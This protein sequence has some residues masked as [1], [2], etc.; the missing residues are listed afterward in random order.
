VAETCP[1][2]VFGSGAAYNPSVDPASFT[3]GVDNPW[4]P[5][6]VGTTFVYSG[7]AD[8]QKAVD[9][10][11]PTAATRLIDG[12]ATR[13]VH[14]RLYHNGVLAERTSDYFAQDRCGNVWYFGED[15]A[16]LDSHG[17]VV[18]T[19]GTWHAGV[20]GAQP[21]VVMQAQPELGRP[22]RQEWLPGQAEDTYRVVDL[23]AAITVPQGSV[24]CALRTEEHS[25]LEPGVIDGKYYARGIG[26]VEE[27]TVKG[28]T[29]RLALVEI[30]D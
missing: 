25:A 5:L 17:K 21:G 16:E 15:T 22:F 20:A 26:E 4:F 29:E 9:R 7:V 27:L 13:V 30:D 18:T 19:D 10:V 6:P 11:T 28:P 12:V 24:S 3:A 1:L 2:P 23:C 14:D 8:G